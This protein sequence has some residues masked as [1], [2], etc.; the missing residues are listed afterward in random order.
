[1]SLLEYGKAVSV[2]GR[3]AVV[4]ANN[5]RAV[6]SMEIFLGGGGAVGRSTADSNRL[7]RSFERMAKTGVN[8]CFCNAALNVYSDPCFQFVGVPVFLA[9]PIAACKV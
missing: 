2:L 9:S 4:W 1:M 5:K 8:V 7:Q 6:C 3:S